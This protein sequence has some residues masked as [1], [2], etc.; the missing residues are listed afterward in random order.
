MKLHKKNIEWRRI[1]NA[2][3]WYSSFLSIWCNQEL[4]GL[5][6]LIQEKL[7]IYLILQNSFE[8]I[9]KYHIIYTKKSDFVIFDR[10]IL[11]F[12]VKSLYDSLEYNQCIEIIFYLNNHILNFNYIRLDFLIETLKYFQDHTYVCYKSNLYHM[13]NGIGTG[14]SHSGNLANLVLLGFEL[15]NINIFFSEINNFNEF[16]GNLVLLQFW[17]RYIDDGRIIM[18]INRLKIEY[19]YVQ[20]YIIHFISILKDIYPE[21]IKIECEFGKQSVF[22]DTTTTIHPISQH[23]ITKIYEKPQSKHIYL[24]QKSNN[25]FSQKIA[26]FITMLFRGICLNDN[27]KDFFEFKKKFINAMICRGYH[28]AQIRRILKLKN[29]PKYKYRKKYLE[30]SRKKLQSKRAAKILSF[31]PHS[32][33][34]NLEQ[35][36]IQHLNEIIM[37]EENEQKKI[38]FIK[39][40]QSSFDDDH[41]Y[42]SILKETLNLLPLDLFEE[43]DIII[44][45]K[46]VTKSENI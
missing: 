31:E 17:K 28:P 15:K 46:L 26:I 34:F 10:Y 24:H 21:N 1:I 7:S 18:D 22:L 45:N 3:H 16:S 32:H 8:S 43:L 30:N 39:T 4:E 42:N 33:K 6:L 37:K 13:V 36:Q 23:I 35:D 12:D 29:I 41:H 27:V 38:F 25:P 44:C 19:Q 2:S 14:F 9:N 20:N 40:Y 11:D 5:I